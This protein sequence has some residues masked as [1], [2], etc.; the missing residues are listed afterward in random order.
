MEQGGEEGRAGGSIRNA[1]TES[2]GQGVMKMRR[3][4]RTWGQTPREAQAH[5]HTKLVLELGDMDHEEEG[6]E[7]GLPA[8]CRCQ[9]LFPEPA[10][11]TQQGVDEAAK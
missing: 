3:R 7:R 5:Q 11:N 4:N 2:L 8:L 9:P 6:E 10:G 1:K